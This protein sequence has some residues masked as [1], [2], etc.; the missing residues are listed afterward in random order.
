M[1]SFLLSAPLRL[2]GDLSWSAQELVDGRFEHEE[3]GGLLDY[4]VQKGLVGRRT[5]CV[6]EDWR[7]G[8]QSF[9]DLGQLRA[10]HAR[11]GIV[12]HYKLMDFW[13]KQRDRFLCAARGIHCVI[14]TG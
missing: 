11:H 10:G 6:H 4:N 12:S 1:H 9:K 13:T 5:A 7:G 2:C 3:A 14:V 8:R